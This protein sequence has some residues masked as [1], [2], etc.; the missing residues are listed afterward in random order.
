MHFQLIGCTS[1]LPNNSWKTKPNAHAYWLMTTHLVLCGWISSLF[2]LNLCCGDSS[3]VGPEQQ[4]CGVPPAWS[5][6]KEGKQLLTQSG[7]WRSAKWSRSP[8]GSSAALWAFSP[9]LVMCDWV[10][11]AWS[12]LGCLP[13]LAAR[14][15]SFLCSGL[16]SRLQILQG[17]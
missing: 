3:A 14:W 16:L 9:T 7:Q 13:G 6:V 5:A 12:Y 1:L 15:L 4:A 2:T 8:S 11:F 17:R 10:C